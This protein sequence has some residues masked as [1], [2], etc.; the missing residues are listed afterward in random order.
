MSPDPLHLVTKWQSQFPSY[1]ID[2][3]KKTFQWPRFIQ[4]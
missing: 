3:W 2:T 4:R 1:I